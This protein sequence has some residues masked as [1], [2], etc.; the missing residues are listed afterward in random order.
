VFQSAQPVRFEDERQGIWYDNVIFPL[1]DRDRNVTRVAGI[2]RNITERK[3][4][5]EFL[6]QSEERYR[7]IIENMEDGYHEVD[8][9]GNF[10]FFNES[11]RKIMGYE[12]EELLGMNNRQYADEENTCKVYQTYNRTYRTGE[13]VKNF[14]W[15]IIR[16]DG[17]RRDI[18]VSISLIRDM[19]SHPT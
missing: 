19:E 7:T 8:I 15:Q 3:K 12:R 17:D 11:M 5:E 4:V 18:E 10:T 13:P 14:E 2:A 6:K 9:K 16:K 1:F